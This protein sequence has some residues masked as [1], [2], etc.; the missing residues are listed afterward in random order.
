M[1]N[2]IILSFVLLLF[3]SCSVSNSSRSS[4]RHIAKSDIIATTTYVDVQTDFSE[5]I[6][7]S[8]K[9]IG[10]PELAIIPAYNN[11]ISD[12]GIDVIVD[13]IF[14]LEANSTK[15][16]GTVR[17]LGYRG[18]FVNERTEVDYAKEK[19]VALIPLIKDLSESGVD[20]SDI[21]SSEFV[22]SLFSTLQ[23]EIE[24]E[25]GDLQQDG[26]F[27]KVFNSRRISQ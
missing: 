27:L 19:I 8:W 7:Y 9:F 14:L 12:L 22:E 25:G 10:N 6:D 4:L 20:V 21:L 23:T 13:P 26:T 24:V 1:K 16:G 11:A 17:V 3:G 18:T 5:K 15:S 2:F